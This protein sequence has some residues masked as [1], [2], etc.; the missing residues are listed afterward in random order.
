MINASKEF[1][2]TMQ[3]RTD[4]KPSAEIRFLNGTVE[5]LGWQDFTLQN[6]SVTDG[7]GTSSFP[8]GVAIEKSIQIELRNDDDRF[9]EFDFIGARVRVWLS[10]ALSESTEKIAYGTFT[11]VSPETYGET[12]II[13][14]VDDMY[15]ADT[16]YETS[17]SFPASLGAAVL[18]VCDRCGFVLQ[19][20]R[21]KNDNFVIQNKPENLTNRE[22]LAMASQ[23]ACGYARMDYAGRL[24]INSYDLTPF[25]RNE[26]LWGGIFDKDTPYSTGDDAYG[27][28]FNP[29]DEGDNYSGGTFVQMQ[30]YHVFY[31]FKSIKVDT[32]DV[33]ITGIQTVADENV[34]LAGSEGYVLSIANQLVSGQEQAAVDLIGKS[35]IGIRFRPFTADHIAYPLAEFGDLAYVVDRKQNAYQTILTDIDFTFLGY[36]TLKCA[37]DS[38]L[39]NSS[40]YASSVDLTKAIV[41]ARK[42][43]E[44]QLTSYDKA[45][46]NMT[47]LMANSMGMFTTTEE[48]ESGG[49][50]EY[51]HDKPTLA[52]S[53]I[54]WKRTELGFMVSQDGGKTWVAGMDSSGNAVVNVL[55]AIGINAEWVSAGRFVV[56]DRQGNITFLAD[57]DTG[58]VIVNASSVSISGS[59]VATQGYAD[60]AAS[61]AVKA[62]TQAD[63]FNRLT[64]NGAAKGLFIRNGQLYFSFSYAEGGTLVLGGANNGN[65]SLVMRNASGSEIGRIDNAGINIGGGNFSANSSGSIS[66]NYGI[67]GPWKLTPTTF[68]TSGY[69]FQITKQSDGSFLINSN[70]GAS[71]KKTVSGSGGGSFSDM[72]IYGDL[73]VS[74]TKSRSID[75]SDFGKVLQYCYETPS[76]MFGDIGTGKTGE[77]G[78][79]Y[80]YFDPVFIET[81]STDC[82]Y[83]V[84]L[85]KEGQGNI[86]VQEKTKEYFVVKGTPDLTFSWEAK[87]KQRDYEYER[88]E[89]FDNAPDEQEPEYAA[90]ADMYIQEFEKELFDYEEIN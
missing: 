49:R 61:D 41:A 22:F 30:D 34:Y 31:N 62:Q 76:P 2:K 69:E 68:L 52:E 13:T 14:A 46:R 12:V 66:F 43:T 86:W 45:V 82:S 71:F 36:T 32:D 48:T 44:E 29:W 54:I 78:L 42:E 8:L 6:N 10:Y 24:C 37:A 15:K 3:E 39:R 80:I 70:G 79:C 74:G 50:I 56:K 87:V 1:I 72:S 84:F 57:I 64:N 89:M 4:F 35:I 5:K 90:M 81:V 53:K 67:L 40:Q 63:I 55:S 9:S 26:G 47:A 85:Q 75:T 77:D 51:Q 73:I 59:S 58:Q 20:A 21:F 33:V 19:T 28:I 38:P 25:E 83:Q 17:L 7:A 27:G 23:I 11:I 16:P 60:G 88:L 18:D 65:G